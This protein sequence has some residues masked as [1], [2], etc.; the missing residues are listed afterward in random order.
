VADAFANI[1]DPIPTLFKF[2]MIENA[3]M[4]HDELMCESCYCEYEQ[5]DIITMSDCGHK[6]C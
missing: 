5:E 6:L 3:F 2:E 1:D 4:A